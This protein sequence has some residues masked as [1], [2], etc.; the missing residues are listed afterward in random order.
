MQKKTL[1]QHMSVELCLGLGVW[2][3][4]CSGVSVW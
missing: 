2:L 3:V 4:C 1:L